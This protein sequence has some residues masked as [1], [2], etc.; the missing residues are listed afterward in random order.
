MNEPGGPVTFTVVVSNTSTI[1][2][3]TLDSLVDDPYGDLNGRGDCAVGAVL[4]PGDTYSCSFTVDVMGQGGD[5]VVDLVTASGQSELAVPVEASDDAVVSILDS[6]EDLLV[7]KTAN[8]NVVQA[9]GAPVEFTV[10]VRNNSVSTTL[11]LT[12]LIDDVF[13]DL[14]GKGDC[15]LGGTIDP[16]TSYTCRFTENIDG[17]GPGLH[18][19]TVAAVAEDPVGR[20]LQDSDRAIVFIRRVMDSVVTAVPVPPLWLLVGALGLAA[21]GARAL[22][23]YRR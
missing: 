18:I 15:V 5:Q 16:Q 11:Q 14:N 3:I 20:L 7:I 17:E 22:R 10:E 2:R 12:S 9:P 19:D 1:S 6:G 4:D 8:P 13:G 21:L 23:R